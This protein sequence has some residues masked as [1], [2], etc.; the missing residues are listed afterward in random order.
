MDCKPSSRMEQMQVQKYK[1]KTG[2]VPNQPKSYKKF[3]IYFIA[4]GLKVHLDV[5]CQQTSRNFMPYEI[6]A[7]LG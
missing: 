3:R 4:I 5:G 1:N 2:K 6:T 7:R